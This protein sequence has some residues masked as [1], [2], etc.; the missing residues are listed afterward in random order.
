MSKNIDPA[1]QKNTWGRQTDNDS[2]NILEPQR[3]DLYLADLQHAA[4][5][6]AAVTKRTMPQI[7]P[8]YVKSISFPEVRLRAEP[9]RR[10][11]VPYQMP[12]WDEPVEP[13][14]ITFLLDTWNDPENSAVSNHSD[15]CDLLDVWVALSRAGRGARAGGY[16]ADGR[17]YYLLDA[18]YGVTCRFNLYVRL[19]R[20]V[21]PALAVQAMRTSGLGAEAA[22]AAA[23]AAKTSTG[24]SVIS[25]M[26]E[27]TKWRL[28]NAWCSGYKLMDLSY[29]ASEL[30]TVEA[31]FYPE[32]IARDSLSVPIT[33]SLALP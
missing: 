26:V 6:I 8:Q 30:M 22:V 24:S 18:S 25:D 1:N 20:G 16:A 14:K 10:S 29:A 3:T 5:G 17:G 21:L 12:S 28:L 4:D 19:L 23:V 32:T 31:S 27:H 7:V 15:V 9:F 33:G 13:V 11:S 2:A